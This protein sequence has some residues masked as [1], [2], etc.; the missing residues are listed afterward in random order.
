MAT[1]NERADQ[2]IRAATQA[3]WTLVALGISAGVTDDD[4][5]WWAGPL[6]GLVLAVALIASFVVI[7]NQ[8]RWRP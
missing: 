1:G 3:T 4:L 6:T 8:E 5:P 7:L 2:V